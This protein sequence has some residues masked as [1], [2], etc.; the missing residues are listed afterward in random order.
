MKLDEFSFVNQQ[1]AGMLKSG[2]PLEGALKQLCATMRRGA[3]RGEIERLEADLTQG[4]PL[5][6]AVARRKLPE[7]YVAMLRVGIQSNDL[8][9]VLNLVADHYQ[10]T[11]ALW[12]RL[13][14]LM[15]YPVIVLCA[16]IGFSAFLSW[17][18]TAFVQ[19]YGLVFSDMMPGESLSPA[20]RLALSMGQLRVP[21]IGLGILLLSVLIVLVVPGIWSGLRWKLPVFREGN[22]AQTAASLGLLIEK[23]CSL[24]KAL[25]LLEQMESSPSARSDFA[26]WRGELAEGRVKFTNLANGSKVF[27]PLF[28]WLVAGAGEN[29]A[30]GFRRAAG[31]YH[32]RA[33]HR[34]EMLLNAAL[35]VSILI[36][37][38]VILLQFLPMLL[39]MASISSSV[40][41]LGSPE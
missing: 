33:M 4:V 32:A 9:G 35:P 27:P 11:H 28:V 21:L 36:L 38:G 12:T 20:A 41:G 37:G 18:F 24:D 19:E 7:F 25:A 13:K 22:L 10:Q 29:L 6:E 30:G 26:R 14:G 15:I 3:L 23:G 17:G 1:L 5:A 34:A 2:I 8:P 16:A 31:V 39:F 40:G